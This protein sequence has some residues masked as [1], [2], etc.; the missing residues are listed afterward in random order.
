MPLVLTSSV[1]PSGVAR[2]T[3]SAAITPP[4]PGRLSTM[5]VAPLLPLPIW[6]AST[7]TSVSIAP[8]GGTEMITRMVRAVCVQ[9]RIARGGDTERRQ[10][11]QHR[12]NATAR[13]ACASPFVS[14]SSCVRCA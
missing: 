2:A 9:A 14:Y 5:M 12:R 3:A 8:P 1:L 13:T 4:A 11:A 10:N 7:R 6:S